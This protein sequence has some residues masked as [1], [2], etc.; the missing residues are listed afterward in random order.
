MTSPKKIGIKTLADLTKL[1]YLKELQKELLQAW[2]EVLLFDNT[3]LENEG[4]PDKDKIFLLQ[5][6][7]PNYWKTFTNTSSRKY[8]KDK[9]KSLLL[10]YG[11]NEN[12]HDEV[13]ELLTNEFKNCT[14]LPSVKKEVENQK[15]YTFTVKV[16][17]KNVQN[18]NPVY[19]SG[20]L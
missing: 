6:R 19:Q 14:L 8:N 18:L 16:N 17:S 10:K 12:V 20:K 15:L 5:C 11:N 13:K 4:L 7:D 1:D 9:F 3:V 2:H